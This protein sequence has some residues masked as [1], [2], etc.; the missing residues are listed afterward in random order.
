MPETIRVDVPPSGQVTALLYPA[1][2][3]AAKRIT[4]IL[5]HGAG[6]NQ[7]SP[8]MIGFARALAERGIDA[9][10]FNF[11]YSEQRRRIP[12]RNDALE[13]CWRAVIDAFRDRVVHNEHGRNRIAIGGKS[14]GGRIASQV[15]AGAA[16]DLLGLV[17]LG[18]PLHPPGKPDQLRSKHL[19]RV[20]APML[21]VQGSRDAFGTPDELRPILQTIATPTELFVIEGGDHSF[22]VPKSAGMSQQAVHA[23]ILDCVTD[24]LQQ[25][26]AASSL[27]RA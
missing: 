20:A 3:T 10:T 4:L 25:I 11:L 17:F 14:M 1:A 24:W 12:D 22:K 27:T 2:A 7:M 23:S 21:F 13:A 16:G 5:G 8:F 19:P 15:A 9:V 18:Y 26:D 6:A